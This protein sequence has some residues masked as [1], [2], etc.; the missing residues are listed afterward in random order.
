MEPEEPQAILVEIAA[1][2]KP[3]KSNSR[4]SAKQAAALKATVGSADESRCLVRFHDGPDGIID[5]IIDQS[6][7]RSR[8]PL[9]GHTGD[10]KD[11]K[12]LR[13]LPGAKGGAAG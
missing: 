8:F 10:G 9:D 13:L 6:W 12:G 1:R 5:Y 7:A 4:L 11:V 2:K 3:V